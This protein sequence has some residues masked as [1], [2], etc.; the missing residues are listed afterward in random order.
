VE[1]PEG[2]ES[3][4]GNEALLDDDNFHDPE[5]DQWWEHETFWF[6]FFEPARRLGCWSYHYVRPNI[7]VTGGG[8]FVFDDTAWFHMET[9]YYINYTDSPMPEERDL[10]DFTFSSG[11]R[12]RMLEPLRRYRLEFRDR[13]TIRFDLDW[14]AVMAPWVRVSGHDMMVAGSAMAGERK[15]R[16]F[17]QFGRVTGTL[18]LHGEEIPIDCLAMRDRSWWH[19]RAE[20]W[21]RNGGRSEYITGA[22]SPEHA[23]FG[24][25]PGGFAVL[26]GVRKPLVRGTKRRE[27]DPEHGF[28]RRVVIEAVDT[29]GRALEVEGESV[30]RMAIP[31]SGVHGVCWQ[32]LMRWSING[33]DAWGD[34]QDAWPIHQWSAFRRGQMG[35]DDARA[36][37]VGDVWS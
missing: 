12:I 36:G 7:G 37:T 1:V 17:D 20:P 11:Q 8:V 6:W 34:D 2:F 32:S 18:V 33:V 10:R 19:R 28:V 27:R 23:F 13:D 5:T 22:A 25:G 9:P 15:A 16:H 21:K 14:T 30:S 3:R 35:L 4:E 31:I 24:A 29:E 26:D